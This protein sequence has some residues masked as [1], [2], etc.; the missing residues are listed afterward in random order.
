MSDL[1]PSEPLVPVPADAAA[2]THC[3]A[4]DYDR[5]YRQSVDDPD[6][7]WAEQ[8]K[9]VDWIAPPTTIAN[10][11]YDPVSIKWFEDG[12]LNLCHN[13]IDRHVA[14]GHGTRTAIIFEPDAPD[15]ETRTISYAALLADVIRMANTLKKLGVRKGDRVTIYM[16]MIPEGA[17]AMLACA[18]IGAVHSVVFGGFSPEAIHGRIEDCASDWVI[19]AD[20]GLRGGKTV[21]LKANVDKALERI[22]VKAVLVIAHTGGDVSM[23]EGRDHWYD[24]LSADVPADCPCEP[25]N[26]EDPLFILYTSGSTGKPKGVLHTVGGYSVWTA[27]TFWYGFDYRPGEIFWCSADIGR[28]RVVPMVAAFLH[29]DVAAGVR[30]NEHSFHV[31]PLERLVD[32]GFQGNDLAAA[33]PL[34]GADHPVAPAI[35]DAAVDRLGREAAEDDAVHRTDARAGEHRD[36]AL[37][38]HR[39]IDGDAVA[40]PDAQLLQRVRETDDVGEQRGIAD[41]PRLA[42]GR[43]G[44]ENDRGAHPVARGDMAVDGVVTEV[45]DAVLIPSDFD[46]VVGPVADFRRRCDPVETPGLLGPEGVGIAHALRI[47]AVVVFC[48]AMRVRSGVGGDGDQ[49]FGGG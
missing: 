38:D 39:H 45:E 42:V 11:S 43:V 36:R 2:N 28:Q 22:D 26:A 27:T 10:W 15:G 23:K 46:G 1:P 33:Q 7:F 5:L 20:E 18:R 32:I 41:R 49:R 47:E 17:V 6:A 12:V 34:V 29:C 14:A 35:L 25:M 16:P 13:A 40:L 30:D 21:P 9:R 44:L 24:A 8:A 48:G 31:D 3:T 37:G 4:A 19:C